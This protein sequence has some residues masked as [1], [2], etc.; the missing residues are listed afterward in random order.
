[1]LVTI[2]SPKIARAKYSGAPKLSATLL[3][4]GEIQNNIID[5]KIPPKVDA[6]VDIPS[7]LPASPLRF[8]GYPSKVVAAELAVPGV[9][10]KIAVI[11]PPYMAPQNTPRSIKTPDSPCIFNVRGIIID[12]PIIEESPGIEPT[13]IPIK[14]P[15]N[16]IKRLNG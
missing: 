7:A 3:K 16:I 1:M 15:K 9:F 6:I 2:E 8:M 14:Q 11:D 12:N 5:E 10:I 4:R 13:K